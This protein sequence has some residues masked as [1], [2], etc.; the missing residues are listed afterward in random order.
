MKITN[1]TNLVDYNT[2]ETM[3][4]YIIGIM[5]GAVK[6]FI[7]CSGTVR[8][9]SKNISTEFLMFAQYHTGNKKIM[10]RIS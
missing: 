4:T 6:L 8:S 2:S 1:L 3:I 5:I 7:T 10:R 9:T